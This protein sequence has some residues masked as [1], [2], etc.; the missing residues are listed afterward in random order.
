M[1]VRMEHQ[2]TLSAITMTIQL[3]LVRTEQQTTQPAITTPVSME[4]L[5]PTATQLRAASMVVPTQIATPSPRSAR[6]LLPASQIR[7]YTL[8]TETRLTM[9]ARRSASL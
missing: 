7:W 9:E 5:S 2:T 1:F 6:V 3:I 4:D 8:S